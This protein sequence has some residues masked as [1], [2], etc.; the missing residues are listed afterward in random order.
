MLNRVFIHI[1]RTGGS[2]VWHSLAH[3]AFAKGIPVC[4]IYHECRQ[5]GGS[6]FGAAAVVEQVRQILGPAVPCLFHHHTHEPIVPLFDSRQTE[7]ATILRD[8]VDRMISAV[9]H[10]RQFMQSDAD[11]DFIAFHAQ[12]WGSDFFAACGDLSVSLEGLVELAASDKYFTTYY[13]TFFAS[14]LEVP[15]ASCALASQVCRTFAVIGHFEDL[16]GSYHDIATRFEICGGPMDHTLNTG[17]K[18]P[19]ISEADRQRYAAALHA[20]YELLAE[21]A[22]RTEQKLLVA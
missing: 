8:P 5:R 6:L 20:D 1:P 15:M 2:S 9:T 22:E 7:Y 14:L 19:A 17:N 4:D 16:A 11:P 18:R 13:T 21:I 12:I 3:A 10:Y